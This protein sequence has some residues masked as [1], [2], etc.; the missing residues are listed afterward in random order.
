MVWFGEEEERDQERIRGEVEGDDIS[1]P[2]VVQ[3]EKE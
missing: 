3:W 1:H 2:V